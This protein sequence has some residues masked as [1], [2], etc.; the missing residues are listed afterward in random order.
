MRVELLTFKSCPNAELTRERLARCLR[1][2]ALDTKIEEVDLHAQTTPLE[3]LGWPSPTV[4]IDG[5]DLEGK[6]AASAPCD[7]CRIYT[8]PGTSSHGA[9]S[10]DLIA[11]ALRQRMERDK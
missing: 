10:E 1:R 5:R 3:Y 9:P 8:S 11:H 7:A 4:L 2:L 6:P